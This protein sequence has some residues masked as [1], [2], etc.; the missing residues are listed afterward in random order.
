MSDT[1]Q[2]QEIDYVAERNKKMKETYK[3]NCDELFDNIYK[4]IKSQSDQ[5]EKFFIGPI[6]FNNGVDEDK[7]NIENIIKEMNNRSNDRVAKNNKAM[8]FA[9][10]SGKPIKLN[11]FVEFKNLT[12]MFHYYSINNLT[13]YVINHRELFDFVLAKYEHFRKE[14][15]FEM[16]RMRDRDTTYTCD[17][18]SLSSDLVKPMTERD[19]VH[20]YGFQFFIEKN[21]IKRSDSDDMIFT[22]DLIE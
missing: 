5:S 2:E 6:D 7:A 9:A 11:E 1:E 18:M 14:V 22:D 4:M 16:Y 3:K 8:E 20:K 15:G 19:V 10:K 13:I 12:V 17:I 21:I